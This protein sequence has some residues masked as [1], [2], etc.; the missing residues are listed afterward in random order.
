MYKRQV[1]H[2]RHP[3]DTSYAVRPVLSLAGSIGVGL[4]FVALGVRPLDH[5]VSLVL[6]FVSLVSIA[7]TAALTL[8]WISAAADDAVG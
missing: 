4:I 1:Q 3:R 7:V 8:A 6:A 5:D 2:G